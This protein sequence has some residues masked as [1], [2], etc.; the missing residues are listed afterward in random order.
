MR[1]S[2]NDRKE[3]GQVTRRLRQLK[4]K[5]LLKEVQQPE[6]TVDSFRELILNITHTDHGSTIRHNSIS[7]L[8]HCNHGVEYGHR[9]YDTRDDVGEEGSSSSMSMDLDES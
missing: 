7:S 3:L 2:Q 6:T 1:W 9:Y 8:V 4:R 5:M